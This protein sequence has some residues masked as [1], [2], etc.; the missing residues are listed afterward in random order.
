MEVNPFEEVILKLNVSE[1]QSEI[2]TWLNAVDNYNKIKLR[3]SNN[4]NIIFVGKTRAGKSNAIN[5]LKNITHIPREMTLFAETKE[6]SLTPFTVE[7]GNVNYNINIIDTPG[8][9]EQSMIGEEQKTDEILKSM[10][11]KCL[12]YEIRKINLIFFVATFVTGINAQ[13]IESFGQF[14]EMFKGAE[15]KICLLITRCEGFSSDYKKMII[16]DIKRSENLKNFLNLIED[17]IFFIG[18]IKPEDWENGSKENIQ[19]NVVNISQMR[20]ELYDLI[21]KT[22]TYCHIDD[23]EI[24]KSQK[25]EAEALQMKLLEHQ[26]LIESLFQA[27]EENEKTIQEFKVIADQL[28]KYKAFISNTYGLKTIE[29]IEEKMIKKEDS[30]N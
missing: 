4:R 30:N 20:T 18:S 25:L 22:D 19:Q 6:P 10:I 9:Y 5:V 24:F 14:L 28:L 1:R 21:F 12:D 29:E 2:R 27:G 13:D 26:N 8:L 11:I 17:R 15:K 3:E 23:F 7:Y 16:A